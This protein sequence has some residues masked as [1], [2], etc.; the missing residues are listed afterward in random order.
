MGNKNTIVI[1]LGSFKGKTANELKTY[2][3]LLL[4]RIKC[5][6]ELAG[7]PPKKRIAEFSLYTQFNYTVPHGEETLTSVRIEPPTSAY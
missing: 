7:P 2:I 6:V 4:S 3:E 1:D 5:E